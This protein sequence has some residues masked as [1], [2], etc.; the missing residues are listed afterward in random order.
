M[1]L[2]I[3]IHF[4]LYYVLKEINLMIFLYYYNSIFNFISINLLKL[5]YQINIYLHLPLNL[6]SNI[7]YILHHHSITFHH[8]H[9]FYHL[10]NIHYKL[11]HLHIKIYLLLIFYHLHIHLYMYFILL[12][13][14]LS[15]YLNHFLNHLQI[16]LY[17]N[18]HYSK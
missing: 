14:Y 4:I 17:I 5:M 9:I 1:N 6:L 15:I 12:L 18:Y 10:K 13:F 16:L 2:I 8:N 3:N 11:Y 7:L